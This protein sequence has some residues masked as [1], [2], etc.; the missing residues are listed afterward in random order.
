M[1]FELHDVDRSSLI[2]SIYT[3]HT[4]DV[5]LISTCSFFLLSSGSIIIDNNKANWCVRVDRGREGG[6]EDVERGSFWAA[7][8]LESCRLPAAAL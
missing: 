5:T 1:T 4:S 2:S 6:R 7:S 8:P 3:V